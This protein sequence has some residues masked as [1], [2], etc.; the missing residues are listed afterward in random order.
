VQ[1][2]HSVSKTSEQQTHT[3]DILEDVIEESSRLET[4]KYRRRY[5]QSGHSR[6]KNAIVNPILEWILSM[7]KPFYDTQTVQRTYR[8]YD[9]W[10]MDGTGVVV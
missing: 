8:K 3:G 7:Y 2:S 6:I 10:T 1:G 5:N 9:S 4:C